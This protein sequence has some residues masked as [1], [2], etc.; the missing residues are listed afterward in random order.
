MIS[1]CAAKVRLRGVASYNSPSGDP[2]EESSRTSIGRKFRA[3]GFPNFIQRRT[4]GLEN[5]PAGMSDSMR[6]ARASASLR[7][8]K[9]L[10]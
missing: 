7:L 6:A 1:W 5:H 10:V 3:R 8:M 2:I 9:V 4:R